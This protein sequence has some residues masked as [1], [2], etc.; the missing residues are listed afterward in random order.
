MMKMK[1]YADADA[2]ALEAARLITKTARETIAV[3]GKFV[4]AVSGGKTPWIM[5]RDLGKQDVPLAP[6]RVGGLFS[7]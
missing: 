2:A 7:A 3:R 5:L 1:V 6:P 4:M